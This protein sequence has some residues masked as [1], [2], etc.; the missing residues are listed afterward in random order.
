MSGSVARFS[1][2][3][4]MSASGLRLGAA[5]AAWLGAAA[6]GA[7]A[8]VGSAAGVA[9]ELVCG[10]V[11]LPVNL[12]RRDFNMVVCSFLEE[13]KSLASLTSYLGYVNMLITFSNALPFRMTTIKTPN[14]LDLTAL[15]NA[16][17]R[18][19]EGWQRYQLDISD[20]QIRDGLIQRFE[21]TYEVS[22]KIL[23]RYLES[24]SATPEEYDAMAFADLIRSGNEQ[25]LLLSDW[26]VWKV[27]REMRGKTSHCYDEDIALEV[28]TSIPKFV[29]EAVYLRDQLASRI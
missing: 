11:F 3:A 1:S 7:G 8:S 21:F 27:Y 24:V 17:A 6:V 16:I 5:L 29:D 25:G 2:I 23:K 26:P 4:R 15:N 22:H 28:V 14:S 18:L 20:T 12:D 13:S 9:L 19:Q 10:L